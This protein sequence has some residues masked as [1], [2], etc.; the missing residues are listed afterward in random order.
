M[1]TLK[2]ATSD[3]RHHHR[4]HRAATSTIEVTAAIDIDA[5]RLSPTDIDEIDRFATEAQR[6]ANQHDPTDVV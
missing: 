4:R 6:M 2:Y 1:L 5:D 3:G